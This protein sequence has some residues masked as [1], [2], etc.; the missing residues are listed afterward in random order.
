TSPAGAAVTYTN[1]TATDAVDGSVPVSCTPAS[2]STFPLATTTV[3]C[4]ATNHAG[5]SATASF[6]VIVKDTTAPGPTAPSDRTPGATGAAGAPV[7]YTA[8]ATDVADPAPTVS[9]LPAS[10]STFPLGATTV[11]CTATDHSGN[12]STASFHVTVKD[13]T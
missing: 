11:N 4:T 7:T 2:G 5:N 12:T 3:N 1:P 6:H 13:T 10:G 9:C 8:T